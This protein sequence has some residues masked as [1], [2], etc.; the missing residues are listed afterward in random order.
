M[1]RNIRDNKKNII[2]EKKNQNISNKMKNTLADNINQNIRGNINHN[3]S[4][5][6]KNIIQ[7]NMIQHTRD[8]MMQNARDSMKQITNKNIKENASHFMKNEIKDNINHNE[9]YHMKNKLKDNM[10]QNINDNINSEEIQ[11]TSISINQNNQNIFNNL[12][13]N[14]ENQ[15]FNEDEKFHRID[16]QFGGHM[17]QRNNSNDSLYERIFNY[18]Y[19]EFHADSFK[20]SSS[21][22]NENE[23]NK[24]IKNN[25]GD[26]IQ[27]YF[28]DNK[29]INN[30]NK[31][32]NYTNNIDNLKEN[33]L[34][35]N[36]EESINNSNKDTN[37][38]NYI[39]NLK[40]KELMINN[41]ESINN[42][43]M[44]I[45]YLYNI[46]SFK[47]KELMLNNEE[48]INNSNMDINYIN[49]IESFKE[50]ELMLNNEES[51][52]NSNMNINY[53]NNIESFKEK[54][55]MKNNEES[56]NN[57]Y[58]NINYTN[59]IYIFNNTTYLEDKNS[60]LN[61]KSKSA[62]EKAF[63]E[64]FQSN[65]EVVDESSDSEES[66]FYIKPKKNI[67]D[68]HINIPNNISLNV[69]NFDIY[70]EKQNLNEVLK[71][72]EPSFISLKEIIH[73]YKPMIENLC[74]A[75][76]FK[77]INEI[78]SIGK[79]GKNFNYLLNILKG[80]KNDKNEYKENIENEKLDKRLEE[81]YNK[82]FEKRFYMPDDM[83]TKIKVFLL[84]EIINYF[85]SIENGKYEIKKLDYYLINE[86]VNRDFN[87][88]YFT[89]YLFSI[90]SNRSKYKNDNYK[91]IKE[92][93]DLYNE[94]KEET[95]YIRF[96]C[97]KIID[98]L[99][100]I[101]YNKKDEIIDFDGKLENF[102][103]KEYN[104]LK[105]NLEITI[106]KEDE[107]F[108]KKDYICSILLLIYNLER[109]YYL[110][111]PRSIRKKNQF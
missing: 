17:I 90:L 111:P 89:Q 33:E 24:E 80:K 23:A 91:I 14:K 18:E 85:N 36:K 63:K 4:D 62:F 28:K 55:L 48:S 56:I 39:D 65:K 57:K 87:L 41:E 92:I 79:N 30:S 70:I 102:I 35:K 73:N 16:E 3:K 69:Y 58:M 21:S 22:K 106:E 38:T 66:R 46:E 99:D 13:L 103:I 74:K 8:N 15:P 9:G 78:K 37:Y 52:N 12:I 59:N 40:E 42:S 71:H 34:K 43:N 27:Y 105:L 76:I 86:Q 64:I 45:N 72:K 68:I 10:K 61:K 26:Y 51:I 101:R 77:K 25:N 95:P 47:E 82:I 20:I 88:K 19:Q 100:I 110:R 5:I 107:E 32:T 7:N 94:K 75:K 11:N 49:N 44:D 1:S 96:L 2:K 98:C 81:I 60:F 50:K 93:I 54:E 104:K 29:S 97:L 53:I 108:I 84:Q 67:E 83:S 31:D 6:L 109:F